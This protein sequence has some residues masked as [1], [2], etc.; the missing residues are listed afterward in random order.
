LQANSHPVTSN[1]PHLHRKLAAV[2]LRH[3]NTRHRAIVS[4]H[5]R[6]AYQALS[7]ELAT[8][9]RPL[10]LDSFC[11]TGHSTAALAANH[12]GH[13]VVGIDQSAQ[14]LD[15]H[16]GSDRANYLLLR[17][18]CEDIWTLLAEDEKVVDFH[19]LLYPNPWPKAR[20]LQR[21]IHGHGSFPQLLRLGGN[22]ELRSNWKVYVEEFGFAMHLAGHRGYVSK[23]A[24]DGPALTLFEQKYRQSG[25]HLWSYTGAIMP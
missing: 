24:E 17:A 10:V 18:N 4:E 19:Y 14:R 22:L 8:N 25:H 5:S 3:L 16:P 21:R 9:P 20:H 12:P 13:L 23:I 2:V 1:Q 7:Q 15:K 6:Q 11:G